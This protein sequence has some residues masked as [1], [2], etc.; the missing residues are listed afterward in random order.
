V[1]RQSFKCLLALAVSSASVTLAHADWRQDLG[2]FHIGISASDVR[3]ISPADL[4]KIEASYAKA[5]G[6][7]VEISVQRDYPAL[8]D[9]H[10]SGRLEYAIYSSTAY[11]SAWLLCECIEPLVAPVLS[12]GSTGTHSVLVVNASVPFTRLDLNGIRV[13][14]PGKDSITG[15]AVP[16]ASYAVGTRSLTPDEAFFTEFNDLESTAAA[17][18]KGELDAFFGWAPAN[19]SGPIAGAGIFGSGEENVL[20]VAGQAIEIKLPWKSGLLRYGPHAVRRDL[21]TEAK[22]ALVSLLSS[23]QEDLLD[24]LGSVQIGDLQKLVPAKQS[25]YE[26]AVQA[27]KAAALN[28]R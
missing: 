10:V 11:A 8:I 28:T 12:D 15:F 13:G 27:A 5:L 22:S 3:S 23:P 18:S 21:S 9:A 7:P 14:I 25:E 1:V 24:L 17:F 19:A 20:N 6:M 16:L 4:D 26:L 2:T